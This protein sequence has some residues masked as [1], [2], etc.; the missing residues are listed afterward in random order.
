LTDKTEYIV[1]YWSKF[2]DWYVKRNSNQTDEVGIDK[3]FW[4][5]DFRW[6]GEKFVFGKHKDVSYKSPMRKDLFDQLAKAKGNWVKTQ[7][8]A[9]GK[10]ENYVGKTIAQ[11]EKR[12]PKA[13]RGYVFLSSTLEL[14]DPLKKPGFGAYRM[15][16]LPELNSVS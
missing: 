7:D 8:L 13:I 5:D 6:E 14:S 4:P 10:P 12:F 16:V 9:K 1:E 2:D 3:P 15:R 11:M